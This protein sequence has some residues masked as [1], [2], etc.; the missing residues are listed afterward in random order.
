[1]DKMSII[2]RYSRIFSERKL[3]EYD[4]SFSEQIIIMYLSMH[5]NVSQDNISRHYMIDK[6]MI[7]KTLNKL[8][9][10]GFITRKQN[11]ENKRENIISLSDNG[12]GIIDRMGGILKEWNEIVYEGISKEDIEYVKKITGIMAENAIKN[13]DA[14]V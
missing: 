8:E 14:K 11:P 13:I 6:G 4:L 7:A 12:I 10:K 9:K 3:K 1:M 2:V 5:D